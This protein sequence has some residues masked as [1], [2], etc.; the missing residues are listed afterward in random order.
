MLCKQTSDDI[1]RDFCNF[2]SCPRVHDN[3]F[4]SQK[5]LLIPSAFRAKKS[6]ENFYILEGTGSAF[7]AGELV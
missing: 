5:H 2:T 7:H 6:P 3:T 1:G 4:S